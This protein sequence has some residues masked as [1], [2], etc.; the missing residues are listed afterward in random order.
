[1]KSKYEL[2]I[3]TGYVPDWTYV[4][5][6]RELFQNAIDNESVNENNKML[7]EYK[8]NTLTIANKTSKLTLDSLLLGSS[9]KRD[10]PKTI[11]QHGE[12]YKIAFMVLLREG[13]SVT[14]LNYGANEIWTTKVV[15]SR[16]YNGA[17]V[18][19]IEVEKNPIWKKTPNSDLSI[20]V[21]NI[22]EEE[23]GHIVDANL[24]LQKNLKA[25]SNTSYG[26]VLFD[27]QH[28]GKVF[29]KGLFVANMPILKL[30]YGYDFT[31]EGIK[32]DRD[33]RLVDSFNVR[34]YASR[35][36][37]DLSNDSK[38]IDKIT[39]MIMNDEADV[40][41]IASNATGNLKLVANNVIDTLKKRHGDKV[42]PVDTDSD[43]RAAKRAGLHPVIVSSTIKN[44]AEVSQYMKETCEFENASITERIKAFRDSIESKLTDEELKEL[45]SIIEDI[46]DQ[47]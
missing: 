4:E 35:I 9:T 3:S 32:L 26:R 34:W 41:F 19:Q 29:V 46:E 36:W 22:T 28:K 20:V 45:D 1:M 37:Y 25:S 18:I 21:D 12:G 43:F 10:D 13:K 24:F 38:Y 39:E 33:R 17:Q 31:T 14:V 16:R 8:D 2:T 5:A 30:N 44:V 23:Y 42:Y 40:Q 7:I 6:V 11:G 27:E 47:L 15:N